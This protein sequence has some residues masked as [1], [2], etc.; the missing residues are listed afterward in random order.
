MSELV[1][2]RNFDSNSGYLE[3]ILGPMFSGKTSHIIKT[4][5][6]YLF[7]NAEIL[8]IN[9]KDD[10]R[11]DEYKLSNHDNTKI[12]CIQCSNLGDIMTSHDH[13]L[14]SKFHVVLINE[15]QFFP[16]LYNTVYTLVNNM[17]HHVYVCGL[18]GDYLLNK[19]GQMLDLIP[20]CDKVIKLNSL[21]VRCR[22]GTKAIFT[23]RIT[24]DTEQMV[25]GTDNYEPLCRKCYLHCT[26]K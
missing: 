16:D 18:D 25:I 6:Q 8:V 7:C 4:Y 10:T 3:V 19:F 9:H 11:Y 5:R 12:D 15:G 1:D 26:M 2:T 17:H 20:L 24:D 21:C 13:I 23:H 14:R 22:N